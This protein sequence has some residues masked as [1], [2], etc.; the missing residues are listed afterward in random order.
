MK[1][2]E[3]FKEYIK[4]SGLR[5]TTERLVILKEIFSL[6]EH[7]DVERLFAN[8]RRKKKN[9][10]RA[11]IYRTMPLLVKIG[12]VRGVIRHENRVLYEHVFGHHHHDHL[13]CLKCG[14][15]I[16]FMNDSIESLQDS[17]CKKFGFKP[18]E[19]KLE[20]QGYCKTC[21]KS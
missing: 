20:V 12:L 11:T 1:E 13:I 16:E 9:I 14:K 15:V 18:L 3:L 6:H 2:E 19:H 5:Y 7:F 4:K 8:L 21:Q 10:S 17:V